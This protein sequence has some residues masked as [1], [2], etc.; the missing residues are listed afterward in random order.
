MR[1]FPVLVV[2]LVAALAAG[3]V[4]VTVGFGSS[5]REAPLTAIDP[6]A[7]DTDVYAFKAPDAPDK[8]TV[9]ANWIPFED[10]A[11]GPNFYRFDDKADYYVNVDNTGDGKYDIR[12]RFKFRTKVRNPDSFLYALPGVSSISDSK[13]N[14]VQTYTITRETYRNGR[15]KHAKRIASGLSV[16]PNDVGPK[17]RSTSAT[18]PGTPVAARTTWRAT[19][20]TRSR[21]RCRSPT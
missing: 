7:D 11:G 1:K 21:C 14:V 20:S 15:L 18:A 16:A 10:P 3:A 4:A 12:Y 17:T 5:H 2:A 8:L 13:L 19:T 9:V 6:T